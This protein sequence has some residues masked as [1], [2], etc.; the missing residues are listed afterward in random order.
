MKIYNYSGK[1]EVDKFDNGFSEGIKTCK[2][3]KRHLKKFLDA[4]LSVP[5]DYYIY[6]IKE[7]TIEST[8]NT[9]TTVDKHGLFSHVERVFAYELYHR[10]SC[11]LFG[12]KEGWVINGEVGKYLR[13]FYNNGYNDNGKQKYPDLVLHKRQSM[14]NPSKNMDHMF[15]CEIKRKDKVSSGIIEDLIK[16]CRFTCQSIE[17]KRGKDG[18]FFEPYNCG[19]Y[20]IINDSKCESP[21]NKSKGNDDGLSDIIVNNLISNNLFI[22][23]MP[24][25]ISI[26]AKKILCVYSHWDSDGD[27]SLSYQSLY[28]I[29]SSNEKFS[30]ILR[31]N[32]ADGRRDIIRTEIVDADNMM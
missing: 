5:R 16:L 10:W 13:W 31:K 20:L 8:P 22:K 29:L 32:V 21:N 14:R 3:V 6:E 1:F 18:R 11:R 24:I 26:E 7:N 9:P 4:V 23:L 19:I 17:S 30:N 27:Y 25:N 12:N 15:V 2:I 28:N